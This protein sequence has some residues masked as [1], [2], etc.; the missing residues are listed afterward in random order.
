MLDYEVVNSALDNFWVSGSE[1]FINLSIKGGV[2][3]LRQ[4]FLLI[5]VGPPNNH[6]TAFVGRF[7]SNDKGLTLETSAFESLYGDQ[8]TLSTQLI[9]PSCLV[10]LS[11]DAAPQKLRNLNPL[12][13]VIAGFNRRVTDLKSGGWY[14]CAID[15]NFVLDGIIV[16][17]S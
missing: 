1:I 3:K 9:K 13:S 10:I 4:S 2:R 14:M 8:F 12:F 17:L 7:D 11:T 16:R 6:C 15:C 5:E